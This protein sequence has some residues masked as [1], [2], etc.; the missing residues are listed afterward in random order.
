MPQ[1]RSPLLHLPLETAS[2][3]VG[4]CGHEEIQNGGGAVQYV[5]RVL[6]VAAN[7]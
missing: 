4:V 6:V 1:V 2:H 3:I 5:Y 7:G